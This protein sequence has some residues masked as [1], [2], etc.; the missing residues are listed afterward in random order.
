MK[1]KKEERTNNQ[2]YLYK[3]KIIKSMIQ[4]IR[5]D[6]SVDNEK[7]SKLNKENFCLFLDI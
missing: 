4:N 3:N 2:L 1:G 5:N 6:N 7:I